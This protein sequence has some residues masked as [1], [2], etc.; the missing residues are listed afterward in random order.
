M[1]EV[2]GSLP[3]VA[4]ILPSIPPRKHLTT[5][6]AYTDL[7]GGVAA[8][9]IALVLACEAGDCVPICGPSPGIGRAAGLTSQHSTALQAIVRFRRA[10][11][12]IGCGIHHDGSLLGDVRGISQTRVVHNP[13]SAATVSSRRCGRSRRHVVAR[14]SGN[15]RSAGPSWLSPT[16]DARSRRMRAKP[17][18]LNACSS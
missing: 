1:E 7:V 11:M 3:L 13:E 8:T 18:D 6:R 12:C 9:I 15:P 16:M 5:S 17:N 4:R 14:S 10:I 2:S